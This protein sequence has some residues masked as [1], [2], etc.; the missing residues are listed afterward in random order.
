MVNFFSLSLSLDRIKPDRKQTHAIFRT[1]NRIL[2]LLLFVCAKHHVHVALYPFYSF[3]HKLLLFDLS[4]C[5][6]PHHPSPCHI[7]PLNLFSLYLLYGL[8]YS[9][10]PTYSTL[11]TKTQIEFLILV[12]GPSWIKY[13]GAY[14]RTVVL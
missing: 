12:C 7:M 13:R 2:L 10:L 6:P 4:H 14:Q 11:H 8:R 9:V 1:Y 3:R 5:N